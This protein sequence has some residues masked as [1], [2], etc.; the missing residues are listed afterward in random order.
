MDRVQIARIAARPLAGKSAATAR[1]AAKPRVVLCC[2]IRPRSPRQQI[3]RADDD[4]CANV[5]VAR[6]AL[7]FM[8]LAWREAC[9]SRRRMQ[10]SPTL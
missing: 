3:L 2:L 1:V 4:G 6:P 8:R 5:L 7:R 9:S 10:R